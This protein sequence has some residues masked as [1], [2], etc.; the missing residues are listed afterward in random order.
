[1]G[2]SPLSVDIQVGESIRSFDFY[3]G[4]KSPI[5]KLPTYSTSDE[6]EQEILESYPGFNVSFKLSNETL[7]LIEEAKVSEIEEIEEAEEVDTEDS[8]V[9]ETTT[10]IEDEETS[11]T[12]DSEVLED[13]EVAPE[14]KEEEAEEPNIPTK[15]EKQFKSLKEA[16][17]WI[18]ETHEIPFHKLSNSGYITEE[19]EKLNYTLVIENAKNK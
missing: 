4:M 1:M 10:L 13:E 14:D 6:K 9:P 18:N 2:A 5:I 11:D 17:L 16:K 8:E 15:V 7:M 3:G 19:F 12:E